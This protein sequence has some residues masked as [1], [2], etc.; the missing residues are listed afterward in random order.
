MLSAIE[1]YIPSPDQ[2]TAHAGQR[3]DG[4]NTTH[5]E[6]NSLNATCTRCRVTTAVT[7]DTATR[8]RLRYCGHCGAA[9]AA[10]E[11]K[12]NDCPSDD[13]DRPLTSAMLHFFLPP[14]EI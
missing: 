13:R 14:I 4:M 8:I 7:G 5:I 11:G 3:K 2:N 12:A 1:G 10:E 9:L 6:K